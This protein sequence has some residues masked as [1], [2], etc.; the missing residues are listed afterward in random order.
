[1]LDIRAQVVKISSELHEKN[2]NMFTNPGGR[3][4]SPSF[5][6]VEH[7]SKQ[8]ENNIHLKQAEQ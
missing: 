4:F 8:Y 5:G 7:N 2:S 6:L 3:L 1:M